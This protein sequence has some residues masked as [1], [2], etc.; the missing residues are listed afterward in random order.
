MLLPLVGPVLLVL[1]IFFRGTAV[2]PQ[3]EIIH[4]LEIIGCQS[5]I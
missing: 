5:T 2:L 1:Q 4:E 3:K